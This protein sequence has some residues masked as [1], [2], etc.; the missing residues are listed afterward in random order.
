VAIG[1]CFQRA[2][3][4]KSE[5]SETALDFFKGVCNK[6]IWSYYGVVNMSLKKRQKDIFPI[7]RQKRNCRQ[8]KFK[9]AFGFKVLV[10]R[11]DGG[12]N[13]RE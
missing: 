5:I 4:R 13:C 2:F 10:Q 8:W 1:A 7:T 3:W 11:F 6:V 12:K 9:F